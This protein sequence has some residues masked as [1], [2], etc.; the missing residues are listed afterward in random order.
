MFYLGLNPKKNPKLTD[1]KVRKAIYQAI[2]REELVKTQLPEGAKVAT[3]LMPDTV[4]G[5]NKSLAAVRYDPET[6]KALLK[7]A[8]AGG[9]TLS[10]RTRPRSRVR[11]CRT[12]R[13][14]TRRSRVTS[15]PPASRSRSSPSRGTAATSTVSTP[16]FD[17]LLLGWTG[18]YDA[19]H[20]FIGTLLRQPRRPTTSRP[21]QPVGHDARRRPGQGRRDR[22]RGRA[23]RGLREDQPAD[24]GGV[25]PR[26]R[27]SATPRRRSSSVKVEG[28]VASPLT[29]EEFSGVTVGGK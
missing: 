14:S 24:R 4:S 18:D 16:T 11:T 23:Q 1:L 28:V 5:Y 9:L 8:G 27:R 22:R 6:A 19:A 25:P 26:P 21:A 17:A 13:R 2:N 3:Q 7:E 12:R 15:R 10:S 20:N 29:A